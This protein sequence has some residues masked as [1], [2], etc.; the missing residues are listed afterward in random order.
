MAEVERRDVTAPLRLVLIN[1]ELQLLVNLLHR[2]LYTAL[3]LR[4]EG[5]AVS[6]LCSCK[7]VNRLYKL[8][9]KRSCIIGNPR[10]R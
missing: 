2:N 1:I 6:V 5:A 10:Q 8:G 4:V 9:D 3:R 7:T